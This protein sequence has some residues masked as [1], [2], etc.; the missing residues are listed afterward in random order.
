MVV[1]IECIGQWCREMMQCCVELGVYGP[2]FLVWWLLWSECRCLYYWAF[3]SV[4]ISSRIWSD[5]VRTGNSTLPAPM[6]QCES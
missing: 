5:D 1:Y 3:W 2:G 6:G 4:Y